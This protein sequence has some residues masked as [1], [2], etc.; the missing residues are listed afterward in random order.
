METLKQP[1]RRK[2]TYQQSENGEQQHI[3]QSINPSGCRPCCTIVLQIIRCPVYLWIPPPPMLYNYI[4]NYQ[5]PNLSLNPP[6]PPCCTIV[7]QIIRC[8][9]Y[10]WIPPPPP[11]LYNCITNY[12]VPNLSPNPPP[13][14]PYAVQLYY[15]LSGAQS[16]SESPPPPPHPTPRPHHLIHCLFTS[17]SAAAEQCHDGF[18]QVLNQ[19]GNFQTCSEHLLILDQPPSEAWLPLPDPLSKP[20]AKGCSQSCP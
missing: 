13:P 14:P 4:T 3:K 2:K 8:P 19:Q 11:M 9:I 18:L 10:L 17:Y 20:D 5:V 15:K 6:P 12:Q 16:I 7:L 1:S